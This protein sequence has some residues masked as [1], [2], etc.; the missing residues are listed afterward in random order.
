ME[1]I[2]VTDDG[3]FTEA[4]VNSAWINVGEGILL[5]AAILFVFLYNF[6]SLLVVSI[7]MPLTIVI[8]KGGVIRF[9]HTGFEKG[10]EK[11]YEDAVKKALGG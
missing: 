1:L 11:E 4:T 5:T 2:W 9:I 6:R 7:T 8:D 3:T 10:R